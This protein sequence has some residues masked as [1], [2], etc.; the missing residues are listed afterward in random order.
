MRLLTSQLRQI[1]RII[2]IKISIYQNINNKEN[3]ACLDSDNVNIVF[4]DSYL[5]INIYLIFFKLLNKT[6]IK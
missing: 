6:A 2:I 4:I 3:I 5:F 1:D